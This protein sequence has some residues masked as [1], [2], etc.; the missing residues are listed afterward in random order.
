MYRIN[1]YQFNDFK[2]Q[3]SLHKSNYA[4]LA[5]MQ[6]KG[7]KYSPDFDFSE[8]YYL[9]KELN[10]IQIPVAYD[11]GQDELFR[12]GKFLIKQNYIVLQHINGYDLVEY[13][14]K[15]DIRSVETI[16]EIIKLFINVC[17]P[18]QYIHSKNYIHCDIKPGHLILSQ[19][20]GLVHL[21]DF[22]L[23]IKKGGVI[24]GISKEYASPEQLQMF[25]F[26]KDRPRKVYYEEISSTIRLDGRTDLYCI[27]LILYQVLA[28]KLWLSE[29]VSPSQTNDQIPGKLVEIVNGLL[30]ANVF[31]R[32][33]SADEL[34]K[35]LLSI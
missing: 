8:E 17:D 3:A 13:L 33:Q 32:I 25:T 24:K 12:D 6:E 26:L 16:N 7:I 20:T 31:N 4:V 22:E 29:K 34:K 15:K 11:F 10:H 23:S 9:L 5:N 35:A 28:K 19:K 18:L 1:Q 21:I 2:C 27:G 30:E 14:E